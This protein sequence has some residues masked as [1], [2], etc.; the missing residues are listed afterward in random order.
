MEQA[1][2]LPVDRA[3]PCGRQ[4][5]RERLFRGATL[6]A[7]LL[8][9]LLL[10]GVAVSLHQ[11]RLAGARAFQARLPHPRDLESGDRQVRRAG[12]DLRHAGDLAHRA[13]WS[14]SR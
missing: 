11:G 1:T 9:L 14:R 13:C 12:A 3:A 2:A 7:A 8:V 5:L 6:A 10:G 4:R